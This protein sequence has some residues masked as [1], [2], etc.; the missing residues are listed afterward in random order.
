M[1]ITDRTI[2]APEETLALPAGP[3][4]AQRPLGVFARPQGSEGWRSWLFTVDHKRIGIMYGAAALFFF[5]VGGAEALF[6]RL[7][8]ATPNGSVIGAGTYNGVFTMHGVTMVFLVIM[9]MAA[10]FA[11]YLLPLQVG[12][13]DVAFPRLNAFSF[14]CFLGGGILLTSSIFIGGWFQN[15]PDGGWFNYAPN[16]GLPF[17]PSKGIDFYA[18]GL[19]ITGIAS[20]V[21]A[22]NLIV[23][24][25]NMRTKG[26]GFFRMPV[27]TWMLLITQF[28]LLFAL[29]VITVALFLLMFD[30]LWGANFFNVAAGADPLLWQ[31]LFWIFGHPEVYILILPSFG[32]VSE[33]IPTFSRKPIF[34]Y[35]FMVAS[36]I[37]IGSW[38]GGCG[39]TTCSPRAW[40]RCRWPRSRCPPC[41][42]PCPPG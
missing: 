40:G 15:A 23:T 10:A 38:A 31:H 35:H 25:L 28:L 36:G 26:M 24:V 19:Q 5:L 14:W 34:G 30:R 16:S 37:A 29:P 12:A 6:I 4:I 13:R 22:I 41:S 17:S 8:L 9:P 2:T 33:I 3:A 39:P 27:L 1:T 21:S 18:V 7:Q 32:I 11:N 42:S 20:L